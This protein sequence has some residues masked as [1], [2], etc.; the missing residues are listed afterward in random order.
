MS[1]ASPV[2]PAAR[3]RRLLEP[4]A[5]IAILLTLVVVVASAFIRHA[6]AGLDC[7]DWPACYARVGAAADA[8]A[9]ST[10]VD[11]ARFLHRF[12][13][14]SVLLVIF[15]VLLLARIAGR[16]SRDDPR[17]T[18]AALHAGAPDS[19]SRLLAVAALVLALGLAVLGV[20]TR[21][22]TLPAV[23]LGNLVGGFA[24]LA[25]L[26]ALA[27]C[28]TDAPPG[29]TPAAPSPVRWLAGALLVLALAQAT[30]G[31][32]IGTQFAL[33]S[34]GA[35][36]LCADSIGDAFAAGGALDPFRHPVVAAGHVVPPAGAGG[37]HA[38]HRAFGIVV[39]LAALLLAFALRSSQRG[40]ATL[41]AALALAAPILGATAL[42]RMPSL[43]ATVLH[44]AV[45]AMLVATLAFVL[46]RRAGAAAR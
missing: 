13:A 42:L 14:S 38:M 21:G 17:H 4:L 2:E 34:C 36:D 31:G 7:A 5:W 6:Q 35:L 30:L 28:V 29:A 15:G 24:L 20:A 12:A 9:P 32:L 22:A 19:R 18:G 1:D 10:G 23:P 39:T 44:N 25:V 40:T 8:Q 3:A 33:R 37:L 11:V 16:G 43:A 41:L 45:A 46:V 26:A 27:G